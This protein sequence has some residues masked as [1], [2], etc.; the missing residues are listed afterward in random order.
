MESEVTEVA[1]AER[2]PILE[3]RKRRIADKQ[4]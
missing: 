3:E 1:E 4:M 2:D